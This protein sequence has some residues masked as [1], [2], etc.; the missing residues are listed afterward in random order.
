MINKREISE[1]LALS[2][3]ESYFLAWINGYYDVTKLY[4]NSFISLKQAFDD[5]SQGAMYQN[6]SFLPRLQDIAEEYGVV[7]H[8]YRSCSVK[9]ATEMLKRQSGKDLYLIR[10]NTSFFTGFKRSS[11]REDHY[12]CVNN[13]LEWINQYP[14]SEG[15]FTEE[16]FSEV[17]DGAVCIYGMKDKT[18]EIPNNVRSEYAFESF[19]IGELPTSLDSLE[20]AIG[21]LRVSRKRLERFFVSDLRVRELLRE[22]VA[23]MDKIYF[24]VHLRK[25]KEMKNEEID[26]EKAYGELYRKILFITDIEKKIS[27]VLRSE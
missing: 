8:E 22:E 12:I 14:L 5:F 21:I 2:C 20:S 18:A 6:Y 1:A 23:C 24:D 17:Y 13:D 11:W 16:R 26:R 4:G 3:V 7:T 27:E 9:E 15:R 19:D 25:L 10:V